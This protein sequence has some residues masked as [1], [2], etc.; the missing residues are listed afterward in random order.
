MAGR[1]F[2]TFP[3]APAPIPGQ[4]SWASPLSLLHLSYVD[5]WVIA[6]TRRHQSVAEHSYR[7]AVIALALVGWRHPSVIPGEY[8]GMGL[9]ERE[10]VMAAVLHDSE[11]VLTGDIPGPQKSAI[12][13]Y[14]RDVTHMGAKECLVKVADSIETGTFWMQWGNSAAWTGHPSNNAPWRDIEKI[15]HYSAKIPGLLDAARAAWATITGGE[16]EDIWETRPAQ[17]RRP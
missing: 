12:P 14:L 16:M 9:T 11:E 15:L 2:T 6:P 7:V 8:V 1:E 10:V 3:E 4:M 13:G 17:Y 5:R